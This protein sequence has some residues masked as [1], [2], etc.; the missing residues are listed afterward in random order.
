MS[1]WQDEQNKI[2]QQQKD[3]ER[4]RELIRKAEHQREQQREEMQRKFR[5]RLSRM[6]ALKLEHIV[7]ALK[8]RALMKNFHPP[9]PGKL[10]EK[11]EGRGDKAEWEIQDAN[12][13]VVLVEASFRISVGW[14]EP[15]TRTWSGQVMYGSKASDTACT[16]IVTWNALGNQYSID[17]LGYGLH[18]N[19]IARMKQELVNYLSNK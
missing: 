15:D 19:L 13:P 1:W 2:R 8:L 14:H 12:E 16:I 9:Y 17:V 3:Q 7:K 10:T 6:A 11:F 5:E 4:Q 18:E